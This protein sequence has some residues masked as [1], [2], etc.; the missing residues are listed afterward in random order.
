MSKDIIIIGGEGN[1]GVIASAIIDMKNNY[2][3]D[4]NLKGYLNDFEQVGTKLH[5]YPVLGGTK[6]IENFARKGYYFVWAVHM[7]GKG[8]K[9]RK[10]YYDLNI[11]EDRL[12]SIIHPKSFVA[13][14]VEIGKGVFVMA[15]SYIGPGTKLGKGTLVMANCVVGHNDDIGELCHLSAGCNVSSYIKIGNASDIGLGAAVLEKRTIG[16][17]S[18]VGAN[19]LLTKD[20]GDREIYVGTPAKLHRKIDK[21]EQN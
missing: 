4:Y 5:E 1:G 15:N 8:E 6:D 19:S 7:I 18:V 11:P 20:M 2:G 17:Y 16:D 10:L 21:H 14:N 12:I 9:R 13:F 3:Y